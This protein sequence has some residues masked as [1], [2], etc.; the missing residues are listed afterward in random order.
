MKEQE[1]V[2]QFIEEIDTTANGIKIDTEL[3][4]IEEW[5]SMGI[6]LITSWMTDNFDVDIKIE[7]VKKMLTIK[8]LFDKITTQ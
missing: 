3:K 7:E 2:K 6:M 1:F 5:D 8:E 4:S